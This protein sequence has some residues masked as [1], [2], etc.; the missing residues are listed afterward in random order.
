M[1]QYTDTIPESIPQHYLWAWKLQHDHKFESMQPK[2]A[3]SAPHDLG[4]PTEDPFVNVN[5]YNY[6]DVSNWRDLNSK[7][8]LMIW[9]DYVWSGST[10]EVVLRYTWSAVRQAMEHLRQYDS[11][12][13]GGECVSWEIRAS[14]KQAMRKRRQSESPYFRCQ[15]QS[16]RLFT[17]ICELVA[18][19]TALTIFVLHPTFPT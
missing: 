5:Q 17:R 18:G 2:S 16:K 19:L 7:Y 15:V 13:D 12:G 14:R 10:D 8:V 3:G 4:S 6:Q 11:D 1:R 9:R